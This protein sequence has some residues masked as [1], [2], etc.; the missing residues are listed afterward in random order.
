MAS[1]AI[2]K[3][4]VG[5]ASCVLL[6]SAKSKSSCVCLWYLKKD[7]Q[8]KAQ[9]RNEKWCDQRVTSH[10]TKKIS[11]SPIGLEPMTLRTPVGY[12]NHWA[13]K[14]SWR[15]GPCTRFMY[16]YCIKFIIFF[17]TRQTPV[18]KWCLP[19]TRFGVLSQKTMRRKLK[20][21]RL[22]KYCWWTSNCLILSRNTVSS[23]SY[24]FKKNMIMKKKL[25]MQKKEYF[26][27]YLNTSRYVSFFEFACWIINDFEKEEI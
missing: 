13:T 18:H 1:K 3:A 6:G 17:G 16:D 5:H 7:G 19:N 8:F 10:G 24:N 14:D 9:W 12:S 23:V 21:R 26:I 11:E 25:M 2:Y 27:R 15:A 22:A 20:I 4:R